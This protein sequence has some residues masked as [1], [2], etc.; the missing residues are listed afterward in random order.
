MFTMVI[1]ILRVWF[2]IGALVAS[3]QLSAQPL[4]LGVRGGWQMVNNTTQ[5]P[6]VAG[7]IDCGTFTNGTSQAWYAG[8]T[9]DYQLLG[10][11]LEATGAVSYSVRPALLDARSNDNFEVLD[12]ATN[13]FVPL[14]RA[15]QY[16]ATL[17][18]LAVEVGLRSRPLADAPVFL[19]IAADAGN[20]I[21]G[22]SFEQTET[23]ASP[24]T[25]LFPN[26]RRQRTNGSG[27]VEA[28]GTAYGVYGGVGAEFLWF[29]DVW[30]GPEVG[31]RLGLNS[32]SSVES[33]KQ[34]M[35]LAGI[36]VRFGV[37]DEIPPPPPDPTPTPVVPPAVV[38]AS[39]PPP[40]PPPVVIA[41]ITTQPLEIRET[42]VTQTFPLLPYIFFDSAAAQLRPK[43]I[44]QG[45]A[46]SEADLPRS[47]LPIY[48]RLLD[49]VG[50][51]LAARPT[52]V[53]TVTGT[54]DG[55]ERGSPEARRE[56]A[57]QRANAIVDILATTWKIDRSRFRIRTVDRP[58]IPSS[59]RYAEGLEE[60]RRVELSS[61][62]EA[63]FAPIVHTRFN[64]Y[65]PVQPRQ[66]FSVVVR[67]AERAL[68]WNLGVVRQATLVD[69]RSADGQPPSTVTFELS[70]A[71]TDRIGPI[72]GAVDSL[73]ATLVVRQ[74]DGSTV[75]ASTQ[76]PVR[77]TVS[78]YEVSRLSLIVF[79]F[80]QYDIS[81]LNKSMMKSMI[82][83]S[84]KEGSRATIR[85]STDKLGEL[86]HNMTL[87]SS[88][89][90]AVDRYLRTVAPAVIVDD[91][92]GIGPSELPYDN[93]LP[94]GR[95]YCRTVSLTITTPLR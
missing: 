57:T 3:H 16:D 69:R 20:A 28:L 66:D 12:P 87:S 62:D 59:E 52:S 60:N 67:N 82:E 24:S 13:S 25:V 53:V 77:K 29:K 31:Y 42:V 41:S 86:S 47:T 93:S 70:Q 45:T 27:T 74:D 49:V 90:N 33:W 39:P 83:Y 17:G 5:L 89:A 37:Q 91:V 38:D 54:T 36:F 43:Y 9:A 6:I 94:E 48:Y 84:A 88:R 64:E 72:I 18:Y 80:D 92:R 4:F 50:Q 68:D 7:S 32:I 1:M 44:V 73:R 75:D 51:R 26:N 40:A 81:D 10:P 15:H 23:I 58:V 34:S 78:N 85:G 71:T 11:L 30:I 2:V 76:F 21:V 65:V 19:R 95:F 46:F 14:Q 61:S 22:A 55:R 79:D 56:L 8:I 63:L 35:I